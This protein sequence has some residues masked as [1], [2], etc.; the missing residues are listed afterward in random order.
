M[1]RAGRRAGTRAMA[2][3][4]EPERRPRRDRAAQIVAVQLKKRRPTGTSSPTAAAIAMYANP[5]GIG[6]EY[7]FCIH[8]STPSTAIATTEPAAALWLKSGLR[9][10][11]ARSPRSRRRR[12]RRGSCGR[13]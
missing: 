4:S 11:S 9:E 5:S 8:A 2:A 7:M 6:A 3:A 12:P 10:R 13:R 1:S